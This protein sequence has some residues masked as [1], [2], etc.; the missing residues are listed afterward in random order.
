M[1]LFPSSGSPVSL[2]R[3]RREALR[4]RFR[5][6]DEEAGFRR[7]YEDGATASRM[8]MLIIG[9]LMIATTPLYDVALLGAPPDF[10]TYTRVLQFGVQVP[11]LLLGV[12]IVTVPGLRPVRVPTLIAGMMVFG[13]SLCAEYLAGVRYGF[14]VPHDFATLSISAL[15][16]LGRLRFYVLLP[17]ALLLMVGITV[18]Q[19]RANDFSPGAIYDCI[20]IWMQFWIALTV[21][22]LLESSARENWRQ[23]RLLETEAAHDGL[24]RLPNRRQFDELLVTRVREA[25]RGGKTIALMMIDVDYFKAFNDL[26]GHPAGDE[27][28]R[29]VAQWMRESMRRPQD[30]CARVGGEEFVAVWF[31]AR[32]DTAPQ[33]AEQLR[34]GV[35]RLA[36][37]HDDSH[38]L[39]VVTAS[40]GFVQRQAPWPVEAAEAVAAEMVAEADRALYQAKRRGRDRLLV[41]QGEDPARTEPRADQR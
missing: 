17:W 13:G 19:L 12:L 25:A 37:R 27:C 4:L 16:L 30:F 41:S 38:G 11:T 39:G 10:V 32:F 23:K 6:P 5:S 14:S 1:S 18:A 33:L 15:C 8:A 24:T 31:D 2:T 7:D 9:I 3:D 35:R 26:Y 29:Q 28:L 22:Y 34:A 21:A 40:G 20:A 36:I